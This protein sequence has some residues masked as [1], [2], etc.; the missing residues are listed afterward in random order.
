MGFLERGGAIAKAFG[1]DAVT[2]H[3]ACD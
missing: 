3:S 1:L 2:H